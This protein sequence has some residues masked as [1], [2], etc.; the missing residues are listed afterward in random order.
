MTIQDADA[1]MAVFLD[2]ENIALGARDAHYP[3][4]NIQKVLERLLLKGHIVVKKA[5]CDFDRYR[6]SNA[7]CTKP[8]LNRS[9]Y[10]TSGSPAITPATSA[11]SWT[12]S[13][14]VT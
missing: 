4:F 13:T 11:W 8:P 9:K 1:T 7:T 14:S 6:I 10:P 2:L 5:Y 3:S 12:R